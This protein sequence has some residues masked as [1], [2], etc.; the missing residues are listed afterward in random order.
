MRNYIKNK[1]KNNKK[2][3]EISGVSVIF[4]DDLMFPFNLEEFREV[5]E[6]VLPRLYL[7]NID[8]IIFGEFDFLLKRH[9]N[10]AY[11]DGAIYVSNTQEGNE[12]VIDDIVHEI[13]HAVEEQFAEYIYSDGLIEK[14][15]LIKRKELHGEFKKE[16]YHYSET[17][18]ENP[19]YDK[20][21]D[22][23]FYD[24]VGYPAMVAINQGIFYSPYG[25]TSLREYF[26]NGFEAFYY[27]KDIYLKRVSPILFSKLESLEQEVVGDV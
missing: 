10:A 24:T 8:Y 6:G 9:Y 21:L 19:E 3:L 5:L 26:A 13:G 12:S 11:K 14:E 15:F 2:F 22:R 16:G 20:Y 18:M 27:H 4:K 23:F 25:A 1:I 17:A 7:N